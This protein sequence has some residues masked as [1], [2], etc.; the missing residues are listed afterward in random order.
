[1]PNTTILLPMAEAAKRVGVNEKTFRRW[2]LKRGNVL[3]V[4]ASDRQHVTIEEADAIAELMKP[5]P[6]RS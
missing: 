3:V 2:A 1:M 4:G 5:R 6:V